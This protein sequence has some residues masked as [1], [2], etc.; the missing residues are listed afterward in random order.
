MVAPAVNTSLLDVSDKFK[1]P[2]RF[3][4]KQELEQPS[5]SFKL[6]GM[7]KVVADSV[8]KAQKQG[9]LDVHVYT[10]SGGNAGIAA[11]VAS[12]HNQ[13]PCTVVLPKTSKQAALD[14][15]LSLGAEVVV[16]GAHWGEADTYLKDNVMA[17][18]QRKNPDI[19]ALYCHPF[20][21]ETL[22]DGHG[23]IVDDLVSQLKE[24]NIPNL[25]LKGIVCS[26][27]GG[28]LYNGIV[29]GLRRNQLSTSILVLETKQTPAFYESVSAD[30]PITL[31][32]V[33]TLTTSLG[34]PYI[35]AKTWEYYKTHPTFVELLDDLD[36]VLGTV[37]YYDQ[38]GDLVEPAC[39]V[40]FAVANKHQN[41]L[42][43]F[44]SLEKDDVV[45][46]VICGGSSVSLE[47]LES[48][49]AMC[50]QQ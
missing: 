19:L 9:K 39:G 14:V 18:A 10:S 1:G 36:A 43:R 38:F 13:V 6:R 16:Y 24:M 48:Y 34:A 47:T 29:T 22:W 37:D 2:C 27:G 49:R 26:C 40:T 31:P 5:G 21:N 30:K 32:K 35:S 8:S 11:A 3:L 28:G 42:E 44:G 50:G 20:D 12:K 46:F 4:F 15:L 45:V 25:K 7:S 41:L 17:A 33:E 23:D